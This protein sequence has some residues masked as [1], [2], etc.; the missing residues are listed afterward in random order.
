M[1]TTYKS[2]ALEAALLSVTLALQAEIQS[3]GQT[4]TADVQASTLDRLKVKLVS[5]N[6]SGARDLVAA[7]NAT[8]EG[9]EIAVSLENLAFGT[10]RLVVSARFG[11]QIRTLYALDISVPQAE[12]PNETQEYEDA[13]IV[14]S[15]YGDGGGEFPTDYAKQGD[16]P[17]A[18][19]TDTQAYAQAAAEAAQS[20]TS[21]DSDINAGKQA[22]AAAITSK[23]VPGITPQD[24]LV[25]MANG[26]MQI[27]QQ[28]IEI[29]G[30]DMYAAQ[31]TGDGALWDLYKVLADMKN[32]FINASYEH[33]G[34]VYNFA[35]LI[36]CEYYKGY[37]S[38]QLQGADAYYTCDGDFYDYASPNHVWH[39]DDN[40]K[41][42]RWV[43]FLYTNSGSR[44]DITNTAISPRSMYI[45]GHIGTIEYFANGRLTDIVCGVED[46]DVIDNFL[47]KGY[48]QSYNRNL[49]IRNVKNLYNGASSA[50]L[51][52]NISGTCYIDGLNE[53]LA[54]SNSV[55]AIQINSNTIVINGCKSYNAYGQYMLYANRGLTQPIEI[56]MDDLEEVGGSGVICLDYRAST[57]IQKISLASIKKPASRL[58]YTTTGTTGYLIDVIVG[59]VETNLY[60]ADWNPTNVLADPTKTATLIDNIKN[61]ILARV[62]DATGGTQLVFTISTNMYNAI[63]SETITWQDQTMTLADAFL[64]KNWLLAGA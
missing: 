10:H 53:S 15:T 4:V 52:V 9:N 54:G 17:T 3:E 40:G 49:I 26:V 6:V 23:G 14:V 58:L 24:T 51:K 7:G 35:A 62:S 37:D 13:A 27:A 41:A 29:D 19:L 44:L 22:I 36:V 59:E 46:T 39:D 20:L 8:I 57:Y 50:G 28:P 33:G 25:E 31:L 21:L 2:I 11:T 18:T 16:D 64:T 60:I 38:L 30:G 55:N 32:R 34:Q 47:Q 48:D 61:H 12:L 42:N 56:Y 43:C 63:A 45:G 5:P 1:K